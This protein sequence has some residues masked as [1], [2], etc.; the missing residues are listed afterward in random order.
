MLVAAFWLAGGTGEVLAQTDSQLEATEARATLHAALAKIT[1]LKGQVARLE[2]ANLAA[3]ESLAAANAE[4][5][6]HAE[7]YRALRLQMEALGVDV[8][9]PDSTGIQQRLLKAVSDNRLLEEEKAALSERLMSLSEAALSFMSTAV[10]PAA[11]DRMAM[12]EEIRAAAS[13]L[14]TGPAPRSQQARALEEAQVVGLKPEFGLLVLDA[15]EKSGV[16]IGMPL[17][18]LRRDRIIGTALVVDV[19]STICGA[20]VQQIG[21]PGES[22]QLGDQVRVRMQKAIQ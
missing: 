6:Q 2:S 3:G 5:R 8:I 11:E 20:L 15:G 1:D 16:R 13:A 17:E 18:V 4:A 12:E 7:S 9:K 10:S 21:Q 19:R 22:V 14:G